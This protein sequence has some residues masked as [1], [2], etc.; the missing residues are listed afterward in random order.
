V[1]D[2]GFTGAQQILASGAEFDA[3]IASNDESAIGAMDA[4]KQAGLR[5]PEDVAVIGFDNRLEGTVQQPPLTSVHVP[6]FNMGY[7]AVEQMWQHLTLGNPLPLLSEVNTSL[8]VRQSCGCGSGSAVSVSISPQQPL[9]QQIAA[10]I[11]KQVFD[12]SEKETIILCRNLTEAFETSLNTGDPLAFLSTLSEVLERTVQTQDDAH[13]WQDA[14]SLLGQSLKER[15][16]NP[17]GQSLLDEARVAISAQM[18]RQYRLYGL[19]ERWTSSRLSLLTARLLTALEEEQIYQTLARYLPDLGIDLC[20]VIT[21]EPEGDDP[22][23]W[24]VLRNALDPEQPLRRFRSQDYPPEG[25]FPQDR[26]FQLSLIPLMVP[27]GQIGFMVFGT[28]HMDLYGAIVQQL[29]S[30]LNA[31]RLY[32]QATEARRAA[33]EANR[34][35][36]RF[37]S[38]I[39]HELRA[40]LNLI[41]G[42]SGLVLEESEEQ[43]ASLPENIRRDLER[44]HAYAQHLGGLLGDVIDLASS[45][46]GQLRLQFEAVNLGETLRVVAES[47]NQ[48][49]LDKG[50]T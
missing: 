42:L 43:T 47:G 49:A 22:F 26:S 24:S 46:A 1:Y 2:G 35:K 4:L 44:I 39:S 31:A 7:Q 45:D 19:H 6:L 33:E 38:T 30:T 37:L 14:V 25:L 41:V 3:L 20:H 28:E 32:R 13:I 12:L 17:F 15:G 5:I 9:F 40:P 16:N 34:L 21:F 27:G 10:H 29:G 11:Q 23:A 36:S 18:Q 48:L 8:V 50:L